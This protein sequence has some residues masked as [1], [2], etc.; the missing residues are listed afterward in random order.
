MFGLFCNKCIN[1]YRWC[2]HFLW[3]VLFRYVIEIFDG[4]SECCLCSCIYLWFM[5][6][7][8]T[9]SANVIIMCVECTP[10]FYSRLHRWCFYG[11]IVHNCTYQILLWLGC[12]VK[13]LFVF[14]H[15][16]DAGDLRFCTNITQLIFQPQKKK[17]LRIIIGLKKDK[18]QSKRE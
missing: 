13:T 17:Y 10:C 4:F 5:L 12:L 2:I 14:A 1:T 16:I 6:A 3:I 18:G 8:E 7:I 15:R 11:Q 9:N